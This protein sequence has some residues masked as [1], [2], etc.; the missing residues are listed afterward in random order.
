MFLILKGLY[1][2]NPIISLFDLICSITLL[3]NI[4]FYVIDFMAINLGVLAISFIF[5]Q[6]VQDLS[7]SD[8][9][10]CSL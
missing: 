5:I 9:K 7:F 3:E 10:T 8:T 6:L 4:N 2:K 1:L